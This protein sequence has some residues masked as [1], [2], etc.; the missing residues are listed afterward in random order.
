MQQLWQKPTAPGYRGLFAERATGFEPATSSLG[1]WH[2]TPELR[3]RVAQHIKKRAN[4][5]P[6]SA[7]ILRDRRCA[8]RPQSERGRVGIQTEDLW[9]PTR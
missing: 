8:T 3:P 4:S 7:V 6:G 1:S 5:N 9:T 2:S